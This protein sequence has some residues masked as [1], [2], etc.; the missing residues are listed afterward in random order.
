MMSLTCGEHSSMS[1]NESMECHRASGNLAAPS[2]PAAAHSGKSVLSMSPLSGSR[3]RMSRSRWYIPAFIHMPGSVA[4]SP[5]P[6][7]LSPLSS[8]TPYCVRS[9]TAAMW[10]GGMAPMSMSVMMSPFRT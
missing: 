2:P 3:S 5:K 9:G 10:L 8:S 4:F 6:D 1:L 7:T